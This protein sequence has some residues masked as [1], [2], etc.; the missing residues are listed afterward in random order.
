MQQGAAQP[1]VYPKDLERLGI[2]VPPSMLREEFEELVSDTFRLAANLEKQCEALSQAR[3]LL[4]P[5][6]M[7]GEIAV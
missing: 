6:L 3:D 2:L 5:R 1:H 4:L 7:N